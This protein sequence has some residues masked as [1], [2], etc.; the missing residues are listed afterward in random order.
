[1]T[2]R[3]Y[4]GAVP[5]CSGKAQKGTS[6]VQ[7]ALLDRFDKSFDYGIY[8]CRPLTTDASTP[9]IH[10]DGRA[11]DLGFPVTNGQP[12]AQGFAAVEVL[13]ANAWE[14]GLMG[15]IWNRTRYDWRTPWGRK[16]TGPSPH[17]DHIHYEQEPGVAANLSLDRAYYLIGDEM[18]FTPAEEKA[19]IALAPYASVLSVLGKGLLSPGPSTGK[20]GNGESLIHMLETYRMVALEPPAISALDHLAMKSRLLGQ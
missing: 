7:A 19:L 8:N 16:Y 11:G 15:I 14:L 10:S 13:R 3:P 17:I 5:P 6:Y 9:S 2:F 20:V 18:P 4:V 12:H 1:V